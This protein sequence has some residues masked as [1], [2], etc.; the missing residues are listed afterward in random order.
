[1]SNPLELALSLALGLREDPTRSVLD[2]SKIRD[3]SPDV[4]DDN[5]RMRVLPAAFWEQTTVEERALFGGRNGLYLFPTTELVDHL[6]EL[7]GD[8]KAIEI[9]AG[10][11]VMAEALGIIATDSHQQAKEPT[12]SAYAFNGQVTV[13]YGPN[14]IDCPASRAVRRYKPE[15]VIGA[16]VTPK[17]DPKDPERGG[18]VEG[19][20]EIDVWSNCRQYVMIGIETQH[21]RSRLWDKPHTIEYPSWLYS[22]ATS[23]GRQ[24]IATW[25]RTA[26]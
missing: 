23:S 26:R 10:N 24:F 22:R 21:W 3:I 11:G 19:I 2:P 20:D 18:N 13:P 16:W 7:I 12:R 25:T 14:V 17:F 4:L 5:G 9:G 1:M 15:V 6:R 8:R